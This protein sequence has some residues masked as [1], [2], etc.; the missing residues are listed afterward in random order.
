MEPRHAICLVIDGL[1]ASALGTYGNTQ[2]AT[3]HFDKLASRSV[4]AEW[5]LADSP[6]LAGFYRAVWEGRHAASVAREGVGQSVVNGL[7]SRG[8]TQS[9]LT[10]DESIATTAEMQSIDEVIS[11]SHAENDSRDASDVTFLESFFA[12]AIDR[13]HRWREAPDDA[14]TLLW[15]HSRGMF[16]PWDAPIHLRERLLDEEDPQAS[17]FTDPPAMLDC[18]DDPDLLLL[19]RIAYAAQIML[20]DTC[21]GAFVSAVDEL[22]NDSET[23]IMVAGSRGFALGEH[24][25]VGTDCQQLHSEQLH[26][27]C[28]VCENGDYSEGRREVSLSQPT[29]IGAC[30]EAWF[31]GDTAATSH[32]LPTLLR[33]VDSNADR[34][35]LAITIGSQV[36][37]MIRTP[38]WQ[39][40]T[41]GAGEQ[42]ENELFTKPDDRWERNDVSSLCP[43]VVSR[44]LSELDSCQ[45]LGRRGEQLP[46]QLSA[47]L[48]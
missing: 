22:F 33:M 7:A 39:L 48:A 32:G 44:L 10:D 37:R 42:Q 16:G 34:R 6:T 25:A 24:G 17:D 31:R 26:L 28:L 40:R 21:V 3:P 30:L 41:C 36:E 18:V 27:P 11:H 2:F 47:E 43:A 12:T 29:D 46:L 35:D 14:D 9:L 23:L 45:Q 13:L 20:L 1:R 38:E 19:Y 8:V 15:F 4:V 5:M